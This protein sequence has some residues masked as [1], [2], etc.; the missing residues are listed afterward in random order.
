MM[1]LPLVCLAFCGVAWAADCGRTSTGLAP[2]NDPFFFRYQGVRGGLY[3]D[4]ANRRPAAHDA[5]GLRL[6]AEVRPRD[7]SGA[8]DEA[9]G[10]IVLLSIGMS[11]T[12][13]EFSVFKPLADRDAAKNPRLVIVDG[14]QGGWSADRI[15]AGGQEYWQEI[16]QR[17]SAARVTP[18]QVQ[19]AW[20]KQADAQ[21]RLPFPEDARRLQGE[22]LIIAQTL[23]A[24][25]PN[26]RLLYLSSRIYG[27]Y[28]S[29]PLNPEPYA[30]QSG[31]AVKWLIEQQIQGDAALSYD[32]RRAPWLAWGPYLWGDGMQMRPDGLVWRCS[33]LQDDGTHPSPSARTKVA[34]M[35]L[36]FFHTDPTARAWFVAP[37]GGPTPMPAALV[38]AA[39][40]GRSVATG[41]LATLFGENLAAGVASASA[42]P[43]PM[44]LGGTSVEIGGEPAFLVYASP[45]QINL[46]MPRA[47]ADP[48]VVVT[49]NGVRSSPLS[50]Q[51]SLYAPGLFTLEG[52]GRGPAAALHADGRLITAQ[53]PARRG[54]TIML[55]VTGIGVRNPMM[56]LPEFLPVVRIG[57]V[58]GEV[59]Y[60]GTAPGFPGLEQIN[61]TV[62]AEAPLGPDVPIEWQI[63]SFRSNTATLAVAASP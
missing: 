9:N 26:L 8:P 48:S 21:P 33:D 28:A 17:L 61:V 53:D 31:F 30:Y 7:A 19:V 24:R 47:P 23:R 50:A 59:S 2:L 37:P 51:L 43:L 52:T 4:G 45:R 38:D 25:F 32:A 39:G 44:T 20:M 18:A 56:R 55:F 40:F 35:L 16:E 12:T 49:R 60:Y 11:N 10:R 3:P 41:S 27:G 42:L 57:G 15:V 6:A 54:E 22:M 36:D 5:A 63:A 13:Q 1:R 34:A 29:T 14:A 46:V 58:S 62:P